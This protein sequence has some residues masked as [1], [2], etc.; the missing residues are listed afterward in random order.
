MKEQIIKR[1][2]VPFFLRQKL[3][4]FIASHNL[5]NK[6]IILHIPVQDGWNIPYRRV[7]QLTC[8]DIAEVKLLLNIE[9]NNFLKVANA[10]ETETTINIVCAG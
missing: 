9:S 8:N 7:L 4:E 5:A 1:Y 3:G 6:P 10:Y 2:K